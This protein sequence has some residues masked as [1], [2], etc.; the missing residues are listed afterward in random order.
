MHWNIFV[1]DCNEIEFVCNTIAV[2]LIL[3]LLDHLR[4]QE[5]DQGEGKEEADSIVYGAMTVTPREIVPVGIQIGSGD[6]EPAKA[7]PVAV[8]ATYINLIWLPDA[9]IKTIND[10]RIVFTNG[11]ILIFQTDSTR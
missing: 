4:T 11:L 2:C 9:F 3:P 5:L 8:T 6:G 10:T 1:V 7:V